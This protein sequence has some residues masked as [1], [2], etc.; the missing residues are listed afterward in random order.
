MDKKVKLGVKAKDKV[1][2]FAGIVIGAA[3]YLTGCNQ[4]CIKS[5]ELHNGEPIDGQ[6]F[7]EG[8]VVYIGTGVNKGEVK[9]KA[10]GGPQPD[11]PNA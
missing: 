11:A 3:Q 2:G 6:W 9:S 5:Q 8:Q 1:S 4:L 10:P 7:D